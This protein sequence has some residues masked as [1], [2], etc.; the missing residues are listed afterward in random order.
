MLVERTMFT[1]PNGLCFPPDE[2]RLYVND[3]D[4]ANI[5]VFDVRT[6]GELENGRIFAAGIFA[7]NTI[8]ERFFHRRIGM[9]NQVPNWTH[10]ILSVPD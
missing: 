4:Q 2:T 7:N 8:V 1:S 10:R 5:R 6:D 3:T 9:A